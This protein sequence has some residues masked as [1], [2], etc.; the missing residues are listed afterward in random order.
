MTKI[1]GSGAGA[2]AGSVPPKCHRS[3]TLLCTVFKPHSKKLHAISL[4]EDKVKD[5]C[6]IKTP[7][8]SVYGSVCQLTGD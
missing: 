8:L 4:R 3:A 2:G 6:P 1:A 5:N 7:K